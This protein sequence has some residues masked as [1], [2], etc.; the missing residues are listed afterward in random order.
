MPTHQTCERCRERPAEVHI[1]NLVDGREEQ[2]HAIA[3]ALG[4][5]Y[6]RVPGVGERDPFCCSSLV[7]F[8]VIIV[9]PGSSGVVASL[10]LADGSDGFSVADGERIKVSY[11]NQTLWVPFVDWREKPVSVICHDTIAFRWQE[12]EYVISDQE[13]DDSPQSSQAES[14]RVHFIFQVRRRRSP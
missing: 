9:Q 13:R 7:H 10:R 12:V 6:L 1:T 14:R 11:E 2:R 5:T 4:R 8:F 3:F